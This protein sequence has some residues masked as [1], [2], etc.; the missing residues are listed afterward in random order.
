LTGTAEREAAIAM[1]NEVPCGH[2]I[3]VG[4]NKVYDTAAFVAEMRAMRVT[5]HVARNT[6]ARRGSNI[7]AQPARHAGYESA[8]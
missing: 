1:L 4:A 8:R 2:R 5:S 7:D 6:N 3:T